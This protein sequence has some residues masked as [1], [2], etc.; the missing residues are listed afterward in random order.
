MY[1]TYKI[2]FYIAKI[3]NKYYIHYICIKNKIL[4]QSE[5]E[6]ALIILMGDINENKGKQNNSN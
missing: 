4:D 6:V 2:P 5:G 3:N 1:E